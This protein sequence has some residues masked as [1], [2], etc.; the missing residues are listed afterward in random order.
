MIPR[1]ASLWRGMYNREL[2][3]VL[4]TIELNGQ[5]WVHY[6][7]NLTDMEHSCYLESFLTKFTEVVE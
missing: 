3:R 4:H 5:T 7:K 6:R 2:V 1:N